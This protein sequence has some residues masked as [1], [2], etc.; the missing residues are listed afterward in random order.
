MPG[1]VIKSGARVQYA[2]VGENAVIGEGAVIGK[3]PEDVEDTE[4]WGIAVVGEDCIIPPGSSVA[5][6]EMVDAEQMNQEAK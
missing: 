1:A 3:R 6:K 4:T 2:I 5:P